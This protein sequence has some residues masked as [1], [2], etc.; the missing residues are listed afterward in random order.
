MVLAF[1]AVLT[2][3]SGFQASKWDAKSAQD[4]A[5]ASRTTVLSQEQATLAG[6]DHLYDVVTF[7]A[8]VDATLAAKP[9]LSAFYE[10]RFRSEFRTAFD[11]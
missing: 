6:Q 2:A 8:W 1:V 7:Q 9:K 5:L 10:R 11:A 3:W 4:S